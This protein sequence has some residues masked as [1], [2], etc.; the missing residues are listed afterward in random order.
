MN[1]AVHIEPASGLC[2]GVEYRWDT[3]T[4]I[5]LARLTDANAGTGMSGSVELEGSDGSWLII[6]VSAGRIR[7]VEVAVWPDV[8]KR[9]ALAVPAAVEDATIV[10]PSRASQPGV[11]SLEVDTAIMCEADTAE[12]LIHFRVGQ[13][14]DVRTV[15][16]GTDLLIELDTQSR[17]AG[18]WLMNVP[19]FPPT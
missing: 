3:D 9:P 6:D 5:L 1:V 16:L 8:H 15:R 17:I 11:A 7:G 12:T 19:P 10:I 4:D 18:L 13:K 14:R 2:P